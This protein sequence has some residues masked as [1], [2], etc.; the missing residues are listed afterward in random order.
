MNNVVGNRDLLNSK[1][2]SSVK[3]TIGKDFMY[4]DLENRKTEILMKARAE[5]LELSII[6]VE[7]DIVNLKKQSHEKEQISLS[8]NMYTVLNR[9]IERTNKN[10][11]N[12][13]KFFMLDNSKISNVHQ[14]KPLREDN[15]KKSRVKSKARKQKSAQNY[16]RNK[17]LKKRKH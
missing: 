14:L 2:I 6:E 4:N 11:L 9:H 10:M 5:I 3:P 1:I 7:R 13:I 12:K 8:H 15:R 17:K 16:S